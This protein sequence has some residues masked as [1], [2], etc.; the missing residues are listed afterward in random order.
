MIANRG[1]EL[2]I[3]VW[4]LF[5]TTF[6]DKDE[7]TDSFLNL[8]ANHGHQLDLI[9]WNYFTDEFFLLSEF[10][11]LE[12]YQMFLTAFQDLVFNHGHQLND[13]RWTWVHNRDDILTQDL[14]RKIFD[15]REEDYA[16]LFNRLEDLREKL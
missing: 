3:N 13:Q 2:M 16:L 9:V 11:E 7:Y 14:I 15:E 6:E 8:L 4:T 1:H 5:I 10:P 12:D